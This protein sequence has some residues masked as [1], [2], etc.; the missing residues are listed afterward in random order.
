MSDGGV[1][2]MR[3]LVWVGVFILGGALAAAAAQPAGITGKVL[4][5]TGA[6]I[7]GAEV[8]VTAVAGGATKAATTGADGAYSLTGL[9]AGRYVLT[10]SKPGFAAFHQQNVRL[11]PGQTLTVNATV[12]LSTVTQSVEVRGT[13]AAATHE[14][15]Q[16]QVFKSD[17]TLRVLDSTQIEALG[18]LAGSGQIIS[19]TP[20]AN[21]T[22]YGNT[23]ATKTTIAING[24]HQGWGGYGGLTDS[25]GIAVSFDGV[26]ISDPAT[27]LWQSPTLPQK[28][29]IQNA[30]VTYGPGD[31]ATRSYNDVGGAIEFTPI[32]PSNKPG[33]SFTADYGRFQQKNFDLNLNTGTHDGW[34]AVLSGGGGTGN[35]YRQG[36]GDNFGNPSQ[37][38]AFYGK[39]LKSLTG[40]GSFSA[41][42]YY[43]NSQ[44]Y[45][46][47]V[48]PTT[49][50]G[51][52]VTGQPGGEVYSQQTSGFYST[53]PYDSYNKD[54]SNIMGLGYARERFVLND[55]TRLE[56]TTWYL[57]IRREHNRLNDVY[58]LGPQQNEFNSPHTNSEGDQVT[59]SEDLPGNAFS[60]GAYF[61]HGLYNTRNNFYNPADGGAMDVVNIGGKIRSG[62]FH[63]DNA[64]IYAQ[65]EIQ[66]GTRLELTPGVRYVRFSTSYDNG[67]LQDFT[68]A[69]GVV[70]STHC[71]ITLASTPG[72]TTDQ[73]AVCTD[74]EARSGVEPSVNLT[75]AA[76]PWL[77]VYGGYSQSLKA[78]QVGGGGGP[79]QKV[80]PRSYHLA[81]QHYYQAGVKVHPDVS[82][83]LSTLLFGAS[84]YHENYDGQEI[85]IDLATGG[86]I[87]AN[88][89]SAYDGVNLYLDESPTG[90]LHLYSN[91]SVER[92]SYSTYVTGGVSYNG[93]P[94]PYV[95]A[96]TFDVGA[97]VDLTAPNDIQVEPTASF[98][99]TG[100]QHL[101]DNTTGAPSSQTMA[102]FG[103]VNL[104]VKVPTRYV[105]FSLAALN[106]LNKEY[107]EYEYI[108]SG[109]YFG[110]A[111]GGYILAYPGA[112]F[113]FYGGVTVHF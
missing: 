11:R 58:S 39:V 82:G 110:T 64:A 44:G 9:A 27:D 24:V 3:K 96:S 62:Y 13:A 32:Q 19:L 97:Y 8:T 105:D 20:G 4:D 43:A 35:S 76:A 30:N 55:R 28:S 109:G 53:L 2:A 48:I 56:N 51:I 86:V 92:A 5:P 93:S 49:N 87:S 6:V 100:S 23:G 50:Q 90:S 31:P 77:T 91:L 25:G 70:L 37:D 73:G 59:L 38:Y 34:S 12:S 29:M 61:I 66:L 95:P 80:D 84:Y 46:A 67:A 101:F 65:D 98:Q 108:S 68:F 41:G 26:P 33:G 15:T 75:A 1:L 83:P 52:T 21:V 7:P 47:Q 42:G 111:N 94:V 63:V 81:T 18:P 112:P 36:I 22:G 16:Q 71:P 85:D 40:R 103:T 89:S 102:A 78:P 17:Q 88:G 10:V 69:P 107:N 79:F 74:T 54:D 113:T 106:V 104:G 99:F 45:R 57:H 60:E 14:P 72:N